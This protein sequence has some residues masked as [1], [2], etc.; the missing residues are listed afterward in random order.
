MLTM[1]RNVGG[2]REVSGCLAAASSSHPL[3]LVLTSCKF[4]CWLDAE[5]RHR[6]DVKSSV[7]AHHVGYRLR[8][9]LLSKDSNGLESR[10]SEEDED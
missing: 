2:S 7:P 5:R 3:S 9:G 10:R 4:T 6:R 1:E 8:L